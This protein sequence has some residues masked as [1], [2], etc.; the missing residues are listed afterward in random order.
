M[1]REK[2]KRPIRSVD[3]WHSTHTWGGV[4]LATLMQTLRGHVAGLEPKYV[5]QTNR[6]GHPEVLRLSPELEA[7][8][9]LCDSIDGQPISEQWGGPIWL[10]VFDRYHYKGLEALSRLTLL[11]QAPPVMQRSEQLGLDPLGMLQPGHSV[12]VA[13]GQVTSYSGV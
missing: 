5:L 10:V 4:W 6:W 13:T 9:L 3:G 8:A 2:V 1:T 12:D 7:N 11:N